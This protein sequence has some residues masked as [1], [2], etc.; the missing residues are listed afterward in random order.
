MSETATAVQSPTEP[1]KKWYKV[2]VNGK[3]CHGGD[4]TWSLPNG[5]QP[6]EWHSI[7]DERPLDI[8]FVGFHLTD[9][10]QKWW[11]NGAECYEAHIEG[12]TTTYNSSDA[13]I[14]CRKVRL[15]RRLND[16]DLIVFSIFLSGSHDV[17]DG[18]AIASGSSTVRA[19]DSSTVRAYDSSTVRA[20][21]SST[22]TA[23]DSSTVRAYG[24][25]TV[26][27]YDSSTV[28]AYDSSTV[29]VFSTFNKI[30]IE[31]GSKAIEVNRSA[32]SPI[33]NVSKPVPVTSA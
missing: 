13:K 23:Y 24:S 30:E 19:S 20:Y 16:N 14:A 31:P 5:D 12:Q 6:G 21:D 15:A 28:R 3:S 25:S 29:V 11:K 33:V 10:P 18:F 17:R 9:Q 22:V 27:A 2:L 1:A 8:C 32:E 26:R 4:F 7:P